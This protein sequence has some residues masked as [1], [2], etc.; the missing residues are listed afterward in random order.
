MTLARR[1]ARLPPGFGA[2]DPAPAQRHNAV[3]AD[4][5]IADKGTHHLVAPLARTGAATARFEQLVHH[6]IG[7]AGTDRPTAVKAALLAELK[8]RRGPDLRRFAYVGF[9]HTNRQALTRAISSVITRE[10]PN[11]RRLG[12]VPESAEPASSG[13]PQAGKAV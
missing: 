13:N 10:L 12:V 6:A 4:Q 7:R 8:R 1:L 11:W 5:A 2:V 9:N 3:F